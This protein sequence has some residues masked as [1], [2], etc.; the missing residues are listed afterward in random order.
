MTGHRRGTGDFNAE[1]EA[2]LQHEIARLREQGMSEED[3]RAEARRA[4]GN[5][6]RAQER[7]FESGTARVWWDHFWQDVRFGLRML[8]RSPGFAAVAILTLAVGIGANAAVFSVVHSV[9]LRPLPFRDAAQLVRI[10]NSYP[11]AWAGLG[12]TGGDLFDWQQHTRTLS[13]MAGWSDVLSGF[14]MTENGKPQRVTGTYASANFFPLLGIQLQ[15]GHGFDAAQDKQGSVPG[16][17]LGHKIWMEDFGADPNVVG[18]LIHLDGVGYTVEGVLPAAVVPFARDADL[19][20]SLGQFPDDFT[21]RVHHNFGVVARLSPGFTIAQAQQEMTALNEEATKDFPASHTKWLVD[22]APQDDPQAAQLRTAL[23][24]LF[25]VVLFVL[26]IACVNLVNLLL[27][28]NA[29]RQVET[30]LRSALGAGR[31]RIVRQFLTET[32]LIALIGGAL[33][34][35][36]AVVTL[37]SIGSMVPAEMPTVKDAGIDGAVLAFAFGLCL[38]AGIFVGLAP[39]LRLAKTDVNGVL[40][41]GGKGGAGA[42][43]H[44]L[45]ATLVVAEIALAIVPLVSAGLLIRSFHKLL[46]VA[47]GFRVEHI[48]TMLVPQPNLPYDQAIKLTQQQAFELNRKQATEFEEMAGRIASLPGVESAGGID[49]LPLASGLK[50][51]SRFLIEGQTPPASGERPVAEIRTASLN[52]FATLGIPLIQGRTF[53]DTDWPVPNILISQELAQR[54]FPDHDA[55]GKRINICTLSPQPCWYTVVG[56][57]GNVSQFGLEKGASFD[58]YFSGG[59]PGY[60]VIRTSGDPE[61]LANAAIG[62][63]RKIDPELPVTQVTTMDSLLGSSVGPRKFSMSLMAVFAGLALFLAAV[64]IYG[65]MSYTVTQ[66]TR[67]I[68]IRVALGAQAGQVLRMIVQRGAA[69]ALIGT[70]LGVAGAFA[71]TRVLSSMLYE[72]K[73]MDPLTFV[74]VPLVLLAVALAACL[75]PARRAMNVDPIVA[76]RHE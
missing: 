70:L 65:V 73:E 8:R 13:G 69:L 58:I 10:S 53:R 22:V 76:L 25:G 57:V 12:L 68:G 45:Q 36:L 14:N 49:V 59:W 71:M 17:I 54:F 5:V 23:E 2:H 43:S 64:G 27:A 46:E 29:G 32:L 44:F 38:V 37:R 55:I 62:E 18:R 1:V 20:I 26:L 30:A 40:K 24:A 74:A 28:R 7:F 31:A 33:A 47:P 16:A 41:Y 66:R 19:W 9:L 67:E 51:A 48:L 11:P 6:T 52:Y 61:L 35:L 63:I 3:A 39:A 15:L 50:Q 4:F 56:V 42:S 60:L 21:S 75:I 34:I 72:V